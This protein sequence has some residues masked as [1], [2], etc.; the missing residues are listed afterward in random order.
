MGLEPS[1]EVDQMLVC[2]LEVCLQLVLRDKEVFQFV[3]EYAFD[4]LHG[5]FVA[6]FRADVFG[7]A[8]ED[9]HA[10]PATAIKESS[11][12]MHGFWAERLAVLAP[13]KNGIALIP[14]FFS[15]DR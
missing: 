1:L 11:E 4:I 2:A 12:E 3:T 9:I 6:A 5:D 8:G 14:E 7:R 10:L 15:D 13:V